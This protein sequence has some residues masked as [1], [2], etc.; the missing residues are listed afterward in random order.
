MSRGRPGRLLALGSRRE[1]L[2]YQDQVFTI[3]VYINFVKR[4]ML[5]PKAH[6]PARNA[7]GIPTASPKRCR[8]CSDRKD[9]PSRRKSHAP[10]SDISDE[11]GASAAAIGTMPPHVPVYSMESDTAYESQRTILHV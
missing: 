3:R 1:H 4:R 7:R 5:R 10:L 6:A 2:P 9:A 11:R 8:G